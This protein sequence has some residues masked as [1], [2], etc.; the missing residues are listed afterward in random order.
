MRP[1]PHTSE[2]AR[3]SAGQR[4]ENAE[5]AEKTAGQKTRDPTRFF[6]A[7]KPACPDGFNVKAR[8]RQ[9]FSFSGEV[10][11]RTC[12]PFSFRGRV[13]RI[14]VGHRQKKAGAPRPGT[15]PFS[16]LFCF[17]PFFGPV[18]GP[19]RFLFRGLAL[20]FLSCS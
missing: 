12:E 18:F 19:F 6:F 7:L 5:G 16:F 2:R 17:A 3:E 15:P 13:R 4:D 11:V 14:G 8:G 1:C 10:K 20:L 9:P